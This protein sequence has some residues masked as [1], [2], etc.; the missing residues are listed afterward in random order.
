MPS[1]CNEENPWTA[2][3][4]NNVIIEGDRRG[5]G[6]QIGIHLSSAKARGYEENLECREETVEKLDP[7]F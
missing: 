2:T 7:K 1:R 6:L 5:G 4:L 3:P